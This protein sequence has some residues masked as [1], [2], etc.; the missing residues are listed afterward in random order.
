MTTRLTVA[1]A[2]HEIIDG[3]VTCES[4]VAGLYRTYA[5]LFPESMAFWSEIAHE[6]E[7]HARLLQGL[8]AYLDQGYTFFN[9][10]QFNQK[11]IHPVRKEIEGFSQSAKAGKAT[12]RDAF[13]AA[14][15]IES[16]LLDARFYSTVTSSSPNYQRVADVLSKSTERHVDAIRN[17]LHKSIASSTNKQA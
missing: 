17:M 6:E 4:M 10:G 9:I 15:T 7:S 13:S 1:K 5:T 16:S 8:H 12:P 11:S 14:L 2:Q 3:L